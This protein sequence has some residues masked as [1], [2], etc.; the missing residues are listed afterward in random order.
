MTHPLL[1]R[2]PNFFPVAI[3]IAIAIDKSRLF[4][5]LLLHL[6]TVPENGSIGLRHG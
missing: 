5:P 6:L 2:G 4:R 3:A 1:P